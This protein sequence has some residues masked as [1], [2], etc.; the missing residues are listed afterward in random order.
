MA[1]IKDDEGPLSNPLVLFTLLIRVLCLPS[2]L[3]CSALSSA[4]EVGQQ[5][6]SRCIPIN[7]CAM[8]R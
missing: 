7:G 5:R 8:A 2:K 3:N 4:Y 6:V 1:K